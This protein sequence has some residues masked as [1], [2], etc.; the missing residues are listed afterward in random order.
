M[1]LKLWPLCIMTRD[2]GAGRERD[3]G[4]SSSSLPLLHPF[5]TASHIMA[6]EDIDMIE[7]ISEAQILGQQLVDAILERAPTEDVHELIQAHAPLWFQS[8]DGTSA[9]HAAAYV[10]DA[11][12]TKLLLDKGAIWNA[13]MYQIEIYDM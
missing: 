4:L 8:Y 10:E 1:S 6:S 7:D 11:E 12:L 3:R 13:S 2:E 5:Y 9:L